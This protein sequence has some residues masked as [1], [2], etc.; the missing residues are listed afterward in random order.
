[1]LQT[2][3]ISLGHLYGHQGRF[4]RYQHECSGH[5]AFFWD[6]YTHTNIGFR[7]ILHMPGTFITLVHACGILC[8]RDSAPH[9]LFHVPWISKLMVRRFRNFPGHLYRHQGCF[10]EH[11]T[12]LWDI[13][14]ICTCLHQGCFSEYSAHPRN[15]HA[16]CTCPGNKFP[17]KFPM[18]FHQPFVPRAYGPNL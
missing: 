9:A 11:F 14:Y 5:F 18:S 6:I 13:H 17:Q 12:H 15:S 4:C 2:L 16:I 8:F 1:M 3:H 7:K 10:S